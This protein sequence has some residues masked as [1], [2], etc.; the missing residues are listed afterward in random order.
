NGPTS[1]D[2]IG[3]P[4]GININNSSGLIIGTGSAPGL[5]TVTLSASNAGGSGTASLAIFLND[6]FA[7]WQAR[8]FSS[9][10]LSQLSL[11]GSTSS[12]AGDGIPNLLKYA[13]NLNPF[14]C[15]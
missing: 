10:Q 6:T 7:S 3:L 12:A 11:S 13:F 14:A 2:A 8:H 15:G 4:A 9:S 1:F 5:T